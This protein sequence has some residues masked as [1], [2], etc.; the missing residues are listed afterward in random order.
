LSKS[1]TVWVG[2]AEVVD[3]L[4]TR[5]RA[6]KIAQDWRDQ[7]YDDVRLEDCEGFAAWWLDQIADALNGKEWGP[8]TCE[9]V[10][11]LVRASG[12]AV[13]DIDAEGRAQ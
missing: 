11:A 6:E 13:G 5:E 10:A 4:V 3:Y 12:R 9:A 8:D 1:W 2:G 7:G